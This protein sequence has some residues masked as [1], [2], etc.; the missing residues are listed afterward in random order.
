MGRYVHGTFMNVFL[1]QFVITD[2]GV[3]VICSFCCPFFFQITWYKPFWI[4][5]WNI[6]SESYQIL[7]RLSLSRIKNSPFIFE[8][9]SFCTCIHLETEH[10]HHLRHLLIVLSCKKVCENS[11]WKIHRSKRC[12]LHNWKKNLANQIA[13]KTFNL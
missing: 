10:G 8:T 1:K 5:F 6:L 4:L 13:P 12:R 3:F 9:F 7:P 2:L 11:L